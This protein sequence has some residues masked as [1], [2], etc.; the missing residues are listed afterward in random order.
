MM[1]MNLT[2]KS[3][4]LALVLRH[5]P[6]EI[7]LSLDEHGWAVVTELVE[8]MNSHG[9]DITSEQLDEI[10]RTD[11][12]K[13]YSFSE[14]RMKIRANQGHS[15]SVD[16]GLREAVPP[17]YLY[18][19]TADKSCDSIERVGLKKMSRLHVHLSVDRATAVK[20][21][22]RHGRVVVYKVFAKD[23]HNDGFKFFLSENNVWLT[24]SV[25]AKYLQFT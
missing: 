2:T 6:E 3:K 23:M 8:K 11:S 14:D 4:F 19:G 16:V 5:K 24:D 18:H 15:V 13:R 7:G 25:P 21:G 17:M 10:V 20:V 1:K 9:S 22:E 12:K